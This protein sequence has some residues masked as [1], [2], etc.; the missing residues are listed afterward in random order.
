MSE[1]KYTELNFSLEFEGEMYQFFIE[2]GQKF[3]KTPAEAA[4]AIADFGIRVLFT[5]AANTD[6]SHG[7]IKR[8]VGELMRMREEGARNERV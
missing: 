6:E 8:I 1:F 7:E 3:Y 4:I 5:G 2:K